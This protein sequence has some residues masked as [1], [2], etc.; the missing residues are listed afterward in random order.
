MALRG[1]RGLHRHVH[2]GAGVGSSQI[3]VVHSARIALAI[4]IA[5][6]TIR[7]AQLAD[8]AIPGSVQL[9]VF[10]IRGT[11]GIAALFVF[12]FDILRDGCH[13]AG[14]LYLIRA[15]D[16]G[17][18]HVVQVRISQRARPGESF[19]RAVEAQ[20]HRRV[21]LRQCFL[22]RHLHLAYVLIC[23]A[24]DAALHIVVQQ[25]DSAS[26][27]DAHR[28]A[29]LFGIGI[30]DIQATRH[31]DIFI[32]ST[33]LNFRLFVADG[34]FDGIV[35]QQGMDIVVGCIIGKAE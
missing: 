11:L 21:D 34:V 22:R 24:L 12:L 25:A 27:A 7:A 19:L 18:G 30:R 26:D 17:V 2:D 35:N 8:V 32:V 13:I 23:T 29:F 4:F 20:P 3:A 33:V 1:R 16:V 28:L 15:A 5:I 14:N 9:A 6:N 31:L 10:Q